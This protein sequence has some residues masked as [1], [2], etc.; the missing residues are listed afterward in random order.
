[1][2]DCPLDLDFFVSKLTENKHVTLFVP[3]HLLESELHSEQ[4]L[5][6]AEETESLD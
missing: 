5:D 4:G 1:M 6:L 3:P 2:K